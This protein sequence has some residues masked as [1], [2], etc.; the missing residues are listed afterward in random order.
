MNDSD[1]IE[2]FLDE[3]CALF[4]EVKVRMD[5]HEDDMTTFKMEAFANATTLAISSGQIEL[6]KTYMDYM[7][8]KLINANPK[9]FEFIDVY[10]VEHLFWNATDVAR[11]VG[12]PLVPS[13][14]KEL[15]VKFHGKSALSQG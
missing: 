11:H 13:K 8:R 6:A 14:L 3:I 5:L 7:D 10:Y 4:P 1:V 15:Y 12:W 9:E 2:V